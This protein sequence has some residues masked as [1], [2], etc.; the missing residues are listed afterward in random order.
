[1]TKLVHYGIG[2]DEVVVMRLKTKINGNRVLTYFNG[3]RGLLFEEVPVLTC[4]RKNGV[5]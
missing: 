4:Q 2:T 3:S 1:M 5:K